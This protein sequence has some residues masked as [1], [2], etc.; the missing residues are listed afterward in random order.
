MNDTLYGKYRKKEERGPK[1][2]FAHVDWDAARAYVLTFD[3]HVRDAIHSFLLDDAAWG[4]TIAH[5]KYV[6]GIEITLWRNAQAC[7]KRESVRIGSSLR[8]AVITIEELKTA[9]ST[10]QKITRSLMSENLHCVRLLPAPLGEVFLRN[11][12]VRSVSKNQSIVPMGILDSKLLFRIGV[13]DY[14]QFLTDSL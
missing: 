13:R 11:G 5:A 1:I 4:G 8:Y 3:Q 7:S 10:F 12:V 6:P 14:S 9:A 2:N